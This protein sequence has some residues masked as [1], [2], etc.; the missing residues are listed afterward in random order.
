M[1]FIKVA[2]HPSMQVLCFS[3]IDD[4]PVLIKVLVHARILRNALQEQVNMVVFFI[5]P[6]RYR[7]DNLHHPLSRLSA[8]AHAALPVR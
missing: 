7:R 6:L 2:V 5:H 4:L 8:R 3:H 1:V